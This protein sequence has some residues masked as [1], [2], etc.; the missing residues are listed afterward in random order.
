MPFILGVV[1]SAAQGTRRSS[2]GS[3]GY[4]T[5]TGYYNSTGQSA[6]FCSRIGN[7]ATTVY[8]AGS[9]TKTFSQA[10]NSGS[11]I[12]SDTALTTSAST[13]IYG[14]SNGGASNSWFD[15]QVGSGWASTGTCP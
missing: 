5:I 3:G 7:A 1:G 13:G 2:G 6:K 9:G 4:G 15:W 14:D 12:Y 10:Y 8:F 11:V